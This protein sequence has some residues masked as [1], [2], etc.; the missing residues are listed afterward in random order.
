[1]SFRPFP[2]KIMTSIFMRVLPGNYSNSVPVNAASVSGTLDSSLKPFSKTFG[3]G[4]DMNLRSSLFLTRSVSNV[5]IEF[6]T[7]FQTAG[8]R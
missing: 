5:A 6:G 4:K 3:P 2:V 8:G 1:M 7:L